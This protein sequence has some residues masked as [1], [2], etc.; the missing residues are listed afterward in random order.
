MWYVRVWREE[1]KKCLKID[2]LK[3]LAGFLFFSI[4]AEKEF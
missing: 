2:T 3:T 4:F 1:E